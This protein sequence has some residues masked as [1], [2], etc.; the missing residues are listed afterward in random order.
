MEY[1]P[2]QLNFAIRCYSLPK[3]LLGLI[4]LLAL[5]LHRD[6]SDYYHV[7]SYRCQHFGLEQYSNLHPERNIFY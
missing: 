7:Y 4:H 5:I 2:S 3:Y 1:F 6:L